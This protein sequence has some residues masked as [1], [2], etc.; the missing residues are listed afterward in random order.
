METSA[1]CSNEVNRKKGREDV[2]QD[3]LEDRP[4]VCGKKVCGETDRQQVSDKAARHVPC[5]QGSTGAR[6]PGVPSD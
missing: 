5:A 4:K 1:P 6:A 2:G 3:D